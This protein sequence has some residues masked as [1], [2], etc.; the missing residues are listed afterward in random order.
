MVI[1]QKK[2]EG[3]LVRLSSLFL[4][5]SV[6]VVSSPLTDALVLTV[7]SSAGEYCLRCLFFP[8]GLEIILSSYPVKLL[9][10]DLSCPLSIDKEMGRWVS[11]MCPELQSQRLDQPSL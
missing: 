10:K 1:L 5:V 6:R 3:F 9:V 4:S 2:R 7:S 8:G 11:S